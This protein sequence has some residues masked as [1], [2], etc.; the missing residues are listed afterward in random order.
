MKLRKTTIVTALVCLLLLAALTGC[1]QETPAAGEDPTNG[2][3]PAQAQVVHVHNWGYFIDRDVLGIFEEEYGIRVIYHEFVNNETLYAALQLGGM[4]ADVIIPSDYMIARMI[5]EEMLYELNFSNI[6]NYTL[7]DPRFRSLAFDPENRF[8]VAYKVG[9]T[10]LIYNSAMIPYE[11]TSWSALFD[12]RFAGQILMFNN[13]RDA[14]AVALQYLGYDINTI[15]EDEIQEAFELLMEQRSILQAYVMD[16]IF[17]KLESGEAWI[18]PW[19]APDFLTMYAHNPDLRFV[20]PAEGTNF[21]V[22]AMVV[23][24][25]S[26]NRT[27]A[28]KFINFM[29]RTDIALMN[30]RAIKYASASYDAAV[31]FAEELNDLER[32]VVFVGPEEYALTEVFYHLPSHILELY[33]RLWIQLRGLS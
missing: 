28:E 3:A 30:M 31:I 15:N 22:N 12:E 11:I 4:I 8:S 23:P 9:T 2:G 20:R 18:G 21:F 1:G 27:N 13:P 10:G 29:V 33:D 32:D 26:E 14:F 16:E 6:P 24:R 7:I 5:E 17:D 25:G 19:Y